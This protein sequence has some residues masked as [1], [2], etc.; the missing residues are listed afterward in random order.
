[1]PRSRKT[2]AKAAKAASKVLRDRR[3]GKASRTVAGSA[4]SQQVSECQTCKVPG[5]GEATDAVSLLVS[6][7]SIPR[8]N[9]RGQGSGAAP[10]RSG[11]HVIRP[12]RPCMSCNHQLD[13]GLVAL[14]V[15]GLLRRPQLHRAASEAWCAIQ[16]GRAKRRI[17]LDQR[18]GSS[19]WRNM[20]VSASRL[21]GL[22]IQAHAS[23]S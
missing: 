22:A 12:G 23:I 5:G 18:R 15:E 19:S 16:P 17:P 9:R 13:M 6:R 3:T 2:G 10:P 21:G 20:S 14:D 7:A 4:L 11:S 1:M 8:R